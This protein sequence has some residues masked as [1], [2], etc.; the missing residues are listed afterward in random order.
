MSSARLE[1][2]FKEINN[3]K[4]N[5]ESIPTNIID[6]ATKEK[7]LA[8]VEKIKM[9]LEKLDTVDAEINGDIVVDLQTIHEQYLIC[10]DSA[11]VNGLSHIRELLA[12]NQS[13]LTQTQPIA[14]Q[15]HGNLTSLASLV[16]GLQTLNQ[17]IQTVVA[18]VS[19]HAYSQERIHENHLALLQL[20]SEI[21]VL[22]N[23]L[24]KQIE[25]QP[26]QEKSKGKW[27][28]LFSHLPAKLFHA[29]KEEPKHQSTPSLRRTSSSD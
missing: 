19:P 25:E 20:G 4:Q 14:Q 11:L 15:I 17:N 29:S 10:A 5:I 23:N 1:R 9:D 28:A 18:K 7:A 24:Q 16:K 2:S 21:N 22:K 26:K 6:T 27:Y 8:V 12:R 13:A 3:I